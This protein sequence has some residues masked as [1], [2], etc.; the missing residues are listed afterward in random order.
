MRPDSPTTKAA[1]A[2][3]FLQRGKKGRDSPET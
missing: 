3:E 2:L 1:L